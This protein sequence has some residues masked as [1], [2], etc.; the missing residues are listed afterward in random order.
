MHQGSGAPI[1]VYNGPQVK[2]N[3]KK[4]ITIV[5]CHI[6]ASAN[7]GHQIFFPSLEYRQLFLQI[8]HNWFHYDFLT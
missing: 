1:H 5:Q 7:N 4:N 8:L 2:M 3:V 6:N